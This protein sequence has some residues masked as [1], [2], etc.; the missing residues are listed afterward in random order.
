MAGA[1]GDGFEETAAHILGAALIVGELGFLVKTFV[2]G[3]EKTD[4]P[5]LLTRHDKVIALLT[6]IGGGF[7]VGLT[8][9]GSGTFFGLV[10]LL[11]FP[12]TAVKV[13]GTDIFHAAALLWVAARATSSR[14][15]ST[16]GHRLA[17]VGSIP[18]VLIGSQV[19]VK[20]PERLLRVGLATVLH[21]QRRQAPRRPGDRAADRSRSRSRAVHDGRTTIAPERPARAHLEKPC[22]ARRFRYR[23]DVGTEYR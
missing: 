7:V 16:S 19:T 5:F 11:V 3:R 9:V 15:T 1:D 10:M 17:L 2:T 14:A 22:T 18:G 20:L 23:L 21:A 12:L 13:V 6:G 4:A 8:S